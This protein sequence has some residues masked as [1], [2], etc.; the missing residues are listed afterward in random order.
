[1]AKDAKGTPTDLAEKGEKKQVTNLRFYEDDAKNLVELA[2]KRNKTVAEL[3]RELFGEVVKK[4]LITE[5]ERR[6]REL[7]GK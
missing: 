2:V 3:Y 4:E 5:T 1:M 7:K 6:L